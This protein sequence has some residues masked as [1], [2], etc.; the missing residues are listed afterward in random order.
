MQLRLHPAAQTEL[1]E[2]AGWYH[3]SGGP[4]AAQRWLAAVDRASMLLKEFPSIG[5]PTAAKARAMVIRR[6]PY[7]LVYRASRDE[8]LVIAVA[9][10]RREP[11]YWAGRR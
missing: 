5:S 11:G 9:H 8:L 10:H 4:V 1:D 2:V 7:S 3:Q 6:F